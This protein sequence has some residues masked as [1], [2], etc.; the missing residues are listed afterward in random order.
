MMGPFD[1]PPFPVYRISPI[2]VAVRKYSGKKR[3]ILDLSSPHNSDI[4][5]INSLIPSHDFSMKYSTVSHAIKLIHLAGRG[6][7]LSKAD[8][9]NAFKVLPLHPDFWPFFGVSWKGSYYFAVRLTFGC[10]SSPKLFNSLSEALCWILTNNHHIP[11]LVHLLDDF[12]IVESPS[13]PLAYGLNTLRKVFADVG[14][15]LS[16]AK[17]IGP[18]TSLEFLGITLDTVKFQASLPLEK[19]NRIALLLQNYLLAPHCT[20]QQLLALLGHLNFALRII[21]QG[22]PF[23]S[24]L[25]TTASSVPN[26]HDFVPVDHSCRT[27]LRLW[28]HLLSNWN[29]ITLF[30]DTLITYPEDIQLFTD[31]APS[32]GFGGYY[33]GR[34]FASAWS[35]EFLAFTPPSA[36]PSS[37]LHELFPIVVAAILW[38]H[39]WSQ[40]SILIHSDNQ[41]TVDIINK[42]RSNSPCIMPFLRRLIWTSV[43]HQFIIRAAH[44]PGHHNLISDS[45]SRL[46]FQKFRQ[47]A[48]DADLHPTPV[49]QFSRTIFT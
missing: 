43:T 20:K 30:Y 28:L 4:P 17:T 31:A 15:P 3:L 41:G 23:I 36:H 11:H 6:A 32:I 46:S 10:K 16:E 25:L 9:T 5:S 18:S 29:G 7:M 26:L 19:L 44:I 13:T 33:Q 38:G 39:E 34:W 49:P 1:R 35:P 2:G 45:L 12:L 47:L 24:H 48:P 22:R 21:P 14:V 40:R 37:A 27:D 42:G 8:I